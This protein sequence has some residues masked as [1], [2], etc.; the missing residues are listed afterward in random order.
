[1]I[2]ILAVI[3]LFIIFSKRQH[4]D[5][6]TL[7][8]YKTN[9]FDQYSREMYE[10]LKNSGF[11]T[12]TLKDFL[13]MEDKLLEYEK[14]SACSNISS[15][16]EVIR[17]SEKIKQRFLGYDFSYHTMHIKQSAEPNKFINKNLVC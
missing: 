8:G 1:M 12:Q 11:S 13:M 3:L 15:T 16:K 7:D 10:R 5:Q 2:F 17:M 9:N 4:S 14:I 6:I